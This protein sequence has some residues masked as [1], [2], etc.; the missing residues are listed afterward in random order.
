MP[1]LAA[2][3]GPGVTWGRAYGATLPELMHRLRHRTHT[4][5]LRYRHDTD[6]RNKEIADR[7]GFLFPAAT[8]RAEPRPSHPDAKQR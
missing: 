4:A 2:P 8:T 7:L 6:K 1:T 3:P 5:A